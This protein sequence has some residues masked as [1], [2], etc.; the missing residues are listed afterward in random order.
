MWGIIFISTLQEPDQSGRDFL[1][2]VKTIKTTVKSRRRSGAPKSAEYEARPSF[3]R[4]EASLDGVAVR[5]EELMAVENC[6]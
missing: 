6:I 4:R 2:A 3:E 1:K 5:S